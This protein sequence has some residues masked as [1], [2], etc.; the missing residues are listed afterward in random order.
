[1]V[2][3]TYKIQKGIHKEK[4]DDS[5]LVDSLIINDSFGCIETKEKTRI[6][7]SDGVGGNAGGDEASVFVMKAIRNLTFEDISDLRS[8]LFCINDNLIKYAATVVG[9]ELMATTVT[10]IFFDGNSC[11]LAHCGNTRVYSLQGSFLK[12]IT[13]DQTTYQWLIS[14]G[15]AKVA[16]QCNKSEIRGAFGGAN[17]KFAEKLVVKK[18][19]E[20]RLPTKILLT[21][22]GIHD[23]LD[24]D[25]IE[26][27]I[28]ND[29]CTSSE[30]INKLI[31]AAVSKGSEDDCTA[32]LIEMD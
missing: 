11:V 19:F 12:Q 3:V 22:D 25:E 13:E 5:A 27:I 4:C 24:I 21:S 20:R 23:I 29:S 9:H 18:I 31:E 15:N 26:N 17:T 28:S 10:G 14:I 1:M 8:E 16:E 30:K 2:I 6:M 7:I 32:I